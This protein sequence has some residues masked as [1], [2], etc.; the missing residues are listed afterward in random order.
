MYLKFP[1]RPPIRVQKSYFTVGCGKGFDATVQ[2]ASERIYFSLHRDGTRVTLIPGA[3]KLW[4]NGRVTTKSVELVSCDRIEWK[5]NVVVFLDDTHEKDELMAEPSVSRKD[6]AL[7]CLEILQQLACDLESGKALGLALE[8]VLFALSEMAGA[9]IGYLISD[10]GSADGWEWLACVGQAPEEGCGQMRRKQL[11]SNTILQEAIQKRRP[12]YV[13]S[14]VG[15]PWAEQASIL[16]AQIFSI[17]CLPLIVE[18]R[19]FGCVYLYTHTPGRSIRKETLGQLNILATQAAL[20]L[21]SRAELRRTQRENRELKRYAPAPGSLL[22]YDTASG[23]SAM[24]ELE[25]RIARLAPADLS[26]LVGG[27]T[28]TGKELVARELHRLSPRASG[29]FVAINCGALPPTLIESTLFGF[30]KGAFTGAQKDQPGKFL[31]ADGGTLFLDEIADLPLDLQ[32]KLLRVLQEKHVEPVGGHHSRHVDFRVIAATHQDIEALV[33]QG[34]F[35][36]DL[37]YRLNGARILTPPLRQR[38]QDLAILARYFLDQ[39]GSP[40]R[41]SKAAIDCMRAHPWPGN[42]RE[43]EQVV[44]RAEALAEGAEIEPGDLEISVPAT[45]GSA[46]LGNLKDAQST[47][48]SGYIRATLEKFQGNRSRAAFHLGI[49]ERT[50][51][52]MLSSD[53]NG[54][55]V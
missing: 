45:M 20:L 54:S 52:R 5:D 9:E 32:V 42:V 49:S 37:Y 2:G 24:R 22:V 30:V 27:E 34:K 51:Y 46:D 7:Q 47:F 1:D 14:I 3:E 33:E 8:R 10:L 4:V 44:R 48:T 11:I 16:G 26:I 55:H 31:Q 29:P 13:E 36:Q 6:F 19:V 18:D 28:G 41:F 23:A 17:G 35:R 43:L 39:I 21:A 38:P 40:R 12:V 25:E 50:L 15:H 53:R